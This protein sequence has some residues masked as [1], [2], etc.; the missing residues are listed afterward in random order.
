MTNNEM[1]LVSLGFCPSS[2]YQLDNFKSNV[3]YDWSD[4]DLDE[5]FE[6]AGQDLTNIRN[7]L[8]EILWL[9]VVSEYVDDK[10]CEREQFDCYVN[11]SLDT[12]FYFK[13]TEVNSEE[14]IKELIN[15]E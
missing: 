13:Q 3:G 4:E 15:E 5:A 10:E 11:G 1:I 7:C 12:H 8:M 6:C 9:K 14:D 2:D